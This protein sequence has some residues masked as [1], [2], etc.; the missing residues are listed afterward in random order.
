MPEPPLQG[1]FEPVYHAKFEAHKVALGLSGPNFDHFWRK[2]EKQLGN[3]PYNYSEEVPDGEGMRM[4]PTADMFPD[5]P[6]LYVYYRVEHQPNKIHYWALSRAW[7]KDDLLP[8]PPPEP[9]EG[10]GE[11]NGL[12][13]FRG[14]D[15]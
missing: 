5:I 3:Y 13:P 12:D 8:P 15:E 6:P 2:V 1:P 11:D 7:S 10:N 9:A 4:L 14:D